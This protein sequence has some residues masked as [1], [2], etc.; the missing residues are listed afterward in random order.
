MQDAV[1][2]CCAGRH[3]HGVGWSANKKP[4]KSV[5][6]IAG[7][8]ALWG[9]IVLATHLLW[10]PPKTGLLIAPPKEMP[11]SATLLEPASI[12][13]MEVVHPGVASERLTGSWAKMNK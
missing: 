12:S 4:L 1:S 9:L 2:C 11:N 8:A 13:L 7:G 10:A 5:L 3:R 6:T